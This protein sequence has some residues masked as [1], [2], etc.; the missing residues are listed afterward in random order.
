VHDIRKK[1]N[2]LNLRNDLKKE[3][4]HLDFINKVNDIVRG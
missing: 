1:E 2:Q 4:D 3:M